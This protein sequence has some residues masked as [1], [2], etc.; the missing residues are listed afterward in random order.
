M[1]ARG[2]DSNIS[3]VPFF[4]GVTNSTFA[5][6]GEGVITI[7]MYIVDKAD[8]ASFYKVVY[9]IDKTAPQLALPNSG[10]ITELTDYT[11]YGDRVA[12][13]ATVTKNDSATNP[14][15]GDSY[16]NPLITQY[17]GDSPAP[18]AIHARP[19]LHAFYFKNLDTTPFTLN[20]T[21]SDTYSSYLTATATS[22]LIGG[23]SGPLVSGEKKF[24]LVT[25]DGIAIEAKTGLASDFSTV[26]LIDNGENTQKKYRLRLYDNTVD[27]SGSARTGNYSETA[28]YAVR[29]NTKPNM[30]GN[31]LAGTDTNLAIEKILYFPDNDTVYDKTITNYNPQTNGVSRF[32]GAT[33][34]Q[35]IQYKLADTGITGNGVTTGTNTNYNLYNA[36]L[37]TM[38]LK[39]N[40]E[41]ATTPSSYP[42]FATFSQRFDN[43]GSADKHFNKVDNDLVSNGTYRKY[44]VQFQ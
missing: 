35:P 3:T 2:A 43:T 44:T 17:T 24:E 36:G 14:S 34:S 15:S 42:T 10:A 16:S 19:N 1:T 12:V 7:R 22:P 8:N 20:N 38:N 5:L 31:G 40:I 33:M 25:E 18:R 29:D 37:N 21:R 32:L 28:F 26:K 23:Y 41:D 11:H 27:P 13:S 30:G 4:S 9:K 39:V 6:Q